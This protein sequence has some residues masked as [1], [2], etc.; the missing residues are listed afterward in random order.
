MK[1]KLMFG[2]VV[3]LF[4]FLLAPHWICADTTS[5]LADSRQTEEA[6]GPQ[7]P[8]ELLQ[9]IKALF[10]GP[11]VDGQEFIEQQF[12]F[13]RT[14]WGQTIPREGIKQIIKQVIHYTRI[15]SYPFPFHFDGISID[16]QSKLSHLEMTFYRN[17]SFRITPDLT[18]KI[19]GLPTEI[20]VSSPKGDMSGSYRLTYH[21]ETPKY[22]FD[23]RLQNR[24]EDNNQEI[25]STFRRHTPEQIK[26]ERVRRKS[27][28]NQK[29]YQALALELKR[30]EH[31]RFKKP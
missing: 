16:L 6:K 15:N 19:L 22:Y 26:K 4:L 17:P 9:V 11:D 21:Y 7:T 23:V 30:F 10:A 3:V 31:P 25:R 13:A 12:G 29:D 18:R 20:W 1:N 27:F 24:A 14:D 2:M 5:K 28:E 8:E